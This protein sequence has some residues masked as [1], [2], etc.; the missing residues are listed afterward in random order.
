MKQSALILFLILS[1]FQL[2]ATR[3]VQVGDSATMS[4]LTCSPGKASYAAF[5]HTAIRYQDDNKGIDMVFNYGMFNFEQEGFYLKF[6]KG[7]TYYML[8]VYDTKYF[9]NEYR[10]DNRMVTSQELLISKSQ[11]QKLLNRL[12]LNQ[13]PE[14]RY[15]LYNFIYDNCA[16]RPRDV[17]VEL[18]E[19][20][21]IKFDYPT[22]EHTFREWVER[23]TG[24][25]TWLKFGIDLVFGK[26]ADRIATEWQAMFLPEV[27]SQ[28]LGAM[29]YINEGDSIYQPFMAEKEVLVP[30]A[31]QKTADDHWFL[32]PF[33]VSLYLLLIVIAFTLIGYFTKRQF[34]L[35]DTLLYLTTGVAGVILFYLMFFSLHPLV[36]SNINIFWCN[37]FHIIVA[38]LILV[39]RFDRVNQIIQLGII[40]LLL[41]VLVANATSF[42]VINVAF[43]PLIV[44]ML[45]RAIYWVYAYR[46]FKRKR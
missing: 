34:N 31:Q 42:Q 4:L 45:I 28:E 6:I 23:Y 5:G 7:T 43:L 46:R 14:N 19:G 44:A 2:S 15:Y 1:I 41:L 36:Q 25:D 3:F 13:L 30:I 8:G 37:P 18:V 27:L 35:I 16:T 22:D 39:R 40:C 33:F 17:L 26:R 10:I 21:K 20:K 38:L 11:K 32:K 29:S 12:M 24:S 9:L